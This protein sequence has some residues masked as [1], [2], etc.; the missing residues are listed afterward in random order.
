[1]TPDEE[2]VF[3]DTGKEK[4]EAHNFT[5]EAMA[6]VFELFIQHDD[7]QY[8][9][10]AAQAAFGEVD[11]LEL[12]LSRFIENSDI[13]R[14]NASPANEPI[15]L[16]LD[17]F[18]CLNHSVQ[19]FKQT[20]GVF[21]ITIGAL[22]ACWLDERKALRQPSKAELAEAHRLTGLDKLTLNED[23]L[24]ATV[25]VEGV[26]F[27]LGGIGKGFAADKIAELFDEWSIET[28]LI[29]A[30]ASSILATNPPKG[31]NGWPLALRNP[32]NRD[33]VLTRIEL[34]HQA[35][36]GS[37]LEQGR[38][39]IDPRPDKQKPVEGKLAAWSQAPSAVTADALSTAFMVM[40]P[41]EVET[42]CKNHPKTG[43]VFLLQNNPNPI[44]YG[45]SSV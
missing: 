38:H 32:K 35:V 25:S 14:L 33:Q 10:Q 8:A 11:R 2:K 13:S 34:A 21:D 18:D 15:S 39:I 23:D 24:T 28:A 19:L 16:G 36:S 26:Q 3:Q 4:P 37:G 44:A 6:T 40:S 17:S 9:E 45:I 27:D 22:Y 42:F 29:L 20:N 41:D 7:K 31:F 30:G 1:V 5:H 12:E 43:A